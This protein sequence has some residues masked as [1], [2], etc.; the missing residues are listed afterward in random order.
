MG[1]G[2]PFYAQ[3]LT[4]TD[5]KYVLLNHINASSYSF[6]GSY[7]ISTNG[8]FDGNKLSVN[9]GT[10][11][12]FLLVSGGSATIRN[13]Y[14]TANITSTAQGIS[15][16]G[17]VNGTHLIENSGFFGSV[18]QP[19]GTYGRVGGVIGG[20]SLGTIRKCFANVT[21]NGVGGNNYGGFIGLNNGTVENCFSVGNINAGAGGNCGGF[22]GGNLAG[23]TVN[24]C[25]SIGS[26]TTS[27]T[28]GGF[29]YSNTGT[30]TNNYWDTVT[31]GILTSVGATGK[32]TTEM[33][34]ETTYSGWD[35]A[36]IW[37]IDEGNDYPKLQ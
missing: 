2:T 24:Y 10:Q 20:F 7:Q 9:T 22:C 37:N 31:S 30:A 15:L 13:I 11:Q 17:L 35:F 16:L 34:Q 27:G 28:K 26:V 19:S 23:G 32:T 4:G 29:M 8:I 25:Y 33:Y 36:T 18:N 21:V 5:K 6:G 12:Y 3:Y 14:L 1:Y